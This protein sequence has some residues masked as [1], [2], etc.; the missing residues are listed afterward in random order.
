MSAKPI[1]AN[2]TM[3]VW[4]AALVMLYI[5]V[6]IQ[7]CVVACAAIKSDNDWKRMFNVQS[8]S[9]AHASATSH[10][11]VAPL[12][13]VD[14]DQR[15]L[16]IC[17]LVLAAALIR[18]LHLKISISAGDRN[19]LTALKNRPVVPEGKTFA[20]IGQEHLLLGELLSTA[21]VISDEQLRQAQDL[22]KAT[23]RL[24]GDCLVSFAW[25]TA[26]QLAEAQQVQE[27][28]AENRLAPVQAKSILLAQKQIHDAR[29]AEHLARQLEKE[30]QEQSVDHYSVAMSLLQPNAVAVAIPSLQLPSTEGDSPS[31]AVPQKMTGA[32][33]SINADGCEPALNAPALWTLEASDH[34]KRLLKLATESDPSSRY[35]PTSMRHLQWQIS[36]TPVDATVDSK[37]AV[38][39]AASLVN[40]QSL[41]RKAKSRSRAKSRNKARKKRQ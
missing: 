7:L 41:E 12:W 32:A 17:S 34:S 8:R 26:D 40:G 23:H 24:L 29:R 35:E 9:A 15:W 31:A 16:P 1:N 13:S 10:N 20:E 39:S 5:T 36:A 18:Y 6:A 11:R 3:I 28:M 30:E 25:I 2:I 21:Q 27:R 38:V 14:L 19:R 4:R 22:S 33:Q 37:P